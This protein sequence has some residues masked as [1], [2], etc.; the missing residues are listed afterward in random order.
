MARREFYVG[1]PAPWFICRSFS[2]PSFHFDTVAGRYVVLTFLGSASNPASAEAIRHVTTDLRKRFND[3]T[4]AFF[5]V[6]TDPEDQAGG[7]IAESAPGIRYF[8]D[9]DRKVSAL[10]G[11][12]EETDGNASFTGFT[13]VL[14]PFLRVVANLPLDD[15]KRHNLLLSKVIEALPPLE[16]HA[17]LSI[18]APVLI[19]PRVF[20]PQFCKQLIQ[21]YE[22]QGGEESGFMRDK[23]GKTVGVLDTNFK[24]RK[25]FH[26]DT[27]PEYED[28]RKAVRARLVRRLVP[29]I[30]K[31]FQF[32]ASRIERYLVAC[33]E[34]ETGG[35]F[36]AHRDNTTKGT[37][38]RRFACTLNLNAEDYEGGELSF[39][40]FGGRSYKAPTGG[41]VVFSCSLLHEASPVTKGKRY[42]F[43]PFLYDD[44]A[45]KIREE[46]RKF[47][48][49]ETISVAHGGA[50]AAA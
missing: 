26:F 30:Q 24:R 49:G 36:R 37:A 20:E 7:R 3:A 23:D 40:E 50:G 21:L 46:N 14:D 38:H 4:L 22:A 42:A 25:D 35:F 15:A 44:A 11:A 31:A 5:G 8:A 27:Q 32:D 33:Y 13:L 2:N 9:F 47:V 1:D 10:Y 28:L 17:G 45:A 16:A 19:L 41:A 48:T 39:P 18:H 12:V 6:S 29:E 34:G 43:L